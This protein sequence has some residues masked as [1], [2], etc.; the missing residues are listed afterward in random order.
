MTF[1]QLAARHKELLARYEDLSQ[2]KTII[3]VQLSSI[4]QCGG[5][6]TKD[7]LDSY[8]TIVASEEDALRHLKRFESIEWVP[9]YDCVVNKGGSSPVFG[10]ET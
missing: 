9:I 4:V 5:K 6:L 1:S 7:Q 3:S 8:L 2:E 10:E